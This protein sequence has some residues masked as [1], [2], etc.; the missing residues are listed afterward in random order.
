MIGIIRLHHLPSHYFLQQLL[1]PQSV[2]ASVWTNISC[3]FSLDNTHTNACF[4]FASTTCYS[5][6]SKSCSLSVLFPPPLPPLLA[7]C[8]CSSRGINSR[9]RRRR[10]P[11]RQQRRQR[12][13]LECC[14]R[15]AIASPAAPA[16]TVCLLLLPP[17]IAHCLRRC[18]AHQMQARASLSHHRPSAH[19]FSLNAVQYQ[20][21]RRAQSDV[22]FHFFSL[23][24]PCCTV[25]GCR[26]RIPCALCCL[27][28]ASSLGL[29]CLCG[30]FASHAFDERHLLLRPPLLL[31]VWESES[32]RENIRWMPETQ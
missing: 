9:R 12:R 14:C 7:P 29:A 23:P 26:A 22:R 21:K 25:C 27:A 17:C 16:G 15:Q 30:T 28:L 24:T 32:E 11:G 18:C 2:S 6:S 8:A 4:C 3:F 20:C 1:L 31:R 5:S 19:F 13:Q 10:Q